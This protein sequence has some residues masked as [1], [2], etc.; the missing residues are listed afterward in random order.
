VAEAVIQQLRQ[1][2]PA[3]AQA[4]AA[5]EP[6]MADL[7]DGL[8][9]RFHQL[10]DQLLARLHDYVTVRSPHHRRLALQQCRE[11]AVDYGQA[12]RD[13]GLDAAQAV[14]TYMVFRRPV[15]DVLGKALAAHPDQGP[16][17]SRILRDAERFMDEVLACVAGATSQA[18]SPGSRIS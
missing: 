18:S 4:A 3:V 12:C 2:Y 5:H 6:W 15:L 13:A 11:I 17:V 1:R 7:Q 14:E 8:R 9:H 10:G 16:E